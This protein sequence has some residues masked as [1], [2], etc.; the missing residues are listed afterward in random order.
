MPN[1]P[2]TDVVPYKKNKRGSSGILPI[3]LVLLL[4]A[5]LTGLTWY[6]T[7][8]DDASAS[9][10]GIIV[11]PAGSGCDKNLVATDAMIARG[12]APDDFV[13][14]QSNINWSA[15][16]ANERGSAAFTTST[17]TNA[18]D[19]VS[20]L[21]ADN[22]QSKAALKALMDE[23]GTSKS[24]LLSAKNWIP[25]QFRVESSWDGN[26]AFSNGRA[27]AAGTRTSSSGDVMWL[28]VNSKKCKPGTPAIDIVTAHRAGCGN[29][30]LALPR[31]SKPTTP[32]TPTPP[33]SGEQGKDHRTSPSTI[34]VVHCPDGQ[35]LDRN[36]Q[37][38]VAWPPSTTTT[39]ENPGQGDGGDGATNTTT[40]PTTSGTAP[41]PPTTSPPTTSPPT[42]TVP[43]LD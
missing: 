39:V 33:P 22:D 12:F 20:Q 10:G 4:I 35:V 31:P 28:F 32:T 16:E 34:P 23:S 30:Q 8:D 42:P 29:P 11:M 9:S 36:T 24:D 37:Q 27:V 40:P 25:V 15:P 43:P 6:F 19:L 41:P 13:V 3:L 17:P 18:K 7:R 38:C 1:R 26:T 5:G 14:G 21:S 2:G